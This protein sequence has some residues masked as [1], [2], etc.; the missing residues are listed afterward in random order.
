MSRVVA[1]S[2]R[3][4]GCVPALRLVSANL[5]KTIVVL[6]AAGLAGCEAVAG[7]QD[8]TYAPPGDNDSGSIGDDGSSPSGDASN[9][10]T[11]SAD[12]SG[13]APLD[14]TEAATAQDGGADAP[15]PSVDGGGDAPVVDARP[16]AT[17]GDGAPETGPVGKDAGDG[18]G[19]G[20]E[21]GPPIIPG[22]DGGPLRGTDGGILAGDLIDNMDLEVAPG[23]IL[24]NGG[25]RGTWFTFYDGTSGGIVPLPS[26]ASPPS[27]IIGTITSF[28]GV[29]TNK[30]AHMTGNGVATYAGMGFN[31]NAL[32]TAMT[33]DA[34]AY[35]GIV[36]WARTGTGT[37]SLSF[38]IPDMNTSA[39][40]GVCTTCGDNLSL[41]PIALT[42]TWQ[43]YVASFNQ[44]RP[45]GF[46][47]PPEA[48][49]DVAAIYGAQFQMT[50]GPSFDVW[51]DD[52][53]FIV[54]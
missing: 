44:L 25:R 14:A 23:S 47:V 9:D 18:G 38:N 20:P 52:V 37:A 34:S 4:L 12:A 53:Y 39:Q 29:T 50:A 28:A 19:S 35:Q 43:Q 26:P 36:F 46:G 30:A 21:A 51:V 22:A 2:L 16:E 3:S 10:V 5:K 8:L 11:T 31:V 6:V 27:A 49:L 13:G 7:I 54:K 24:A 41:P 42:T 45:Q 1:L 33:Y 40:G 17:P 15:S 48:A 32:A